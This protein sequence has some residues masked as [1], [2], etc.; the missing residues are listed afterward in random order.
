MSGRFRVIVL[1]SAVALSFAFFSVTQAGQARSPESQTYSFTVSDVLDCGTFL[2]NFTDYYTIRD[3]LYF[4]R[5]AA[6]A[7][8][9]LHV[10]HYSTDTNS[11]TG[12]SLHEHDYFIIIIDYV[13]GT[14][15]INGAEFVMNRSGQ[16]IVLQDTGR[17]VF[18]DSGVIFQAGPHQANTQGD[19]AWCIA[20]G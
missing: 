9:T 3:T 4:D 2:D 19:E 13:A 20:L 7:R 6:P 11:V 14:W 15:T 12:L 1:L 18:G 10:D 5:S 8:E 16:G 17:I